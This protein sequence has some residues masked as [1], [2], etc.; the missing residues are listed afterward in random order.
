M[1]TAVFYNFFIE[2]NLMASIAIVLMMVIRKYLRR[3]LGSSALCFGWLLVALRLMLPISFVNPLI[4]TIRSPFAPDIAI[5]PIAGQIKVRLGDMIDAIGRSLW[6]AGNRAGS[7]AI[8][9]VRT[10]ME[11]GIISIQIFHIYLIGLILVALWL[12]YRNARFYR[13]LAKGRVGT[14]SDEQTARYHALCAARNVKPV[15]VYLV[16]PL[17]A[18]GL[19][20]VFRPHIVL[21]LTTPPEETDMTLTH[22]LCHLKSHDNLWS[23]LRL[24][25][26][27]VHWFNPLVWMAA[28]MSRTDLEMKC[29]DAVTRMMDEQQKEAYAKVLVQSAARKP[30]MGLALLEACMT[31]TG[32]K[33]KQRVS[34]I[35][36]GKSPVRAFS[37]A[38]V[39][40]AAMCLAGAFATSETAEQIAMGVSPYVEEK[41]LTDHLKGAASLKD[42]AAAE[43]YAKE[44]IEQMDPALKGLTA[45]E[46]SR[47]G[48]WFYVPFIGKDGQEVFCEVAP[49]GLVRTYRRPTPRIWEKSPKPPMVDYLHDATAKNAL[50]KAAY[51]QAELLAPGCT[52]FITETEVFSI[53]TD[54]TGDYVSLS[55]QTKDG[56]FEPFFIMHISPDGTRRLMDCTFAGN[57]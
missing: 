31:M 2:A 39:V 4:H 34:S 42:E 6:K 9:D 12:I 5:R 44:L 19:V 21:P 51:E 54:D 43:A 3:P 32:K 55:T 30:A 7:R 50:V 1:R 53:W 41:Y 18:A 47:D 57:G 14:L 48:K 28:S 46:I 20:G 27:A 29:D 40:I 25:C 33:L 16:D 23:L 35:V 56:Y 45:N 11:S 22:E 26:C 38:F 17:P 8:S 36:K 15:P 37:V 24:V 10:D 52:A 49:N 13:A